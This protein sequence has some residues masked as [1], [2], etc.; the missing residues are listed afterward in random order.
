MTE[1][2]G[3]T[4]LVTGAA[5]GMGRLMALRFAALGGRVVLWDLDEAGVTRAADEIAA[6][7]GANVVADAVDV[8]DRE[9]V[10]E[11]A[12]QATERAGP[13]DVLVHSAGVTHGGLLL[14]HP[15]EVIEQTLR[16]NTL[17]LFW[18]TKAFLPAMLERNDGHVVTMGSAS[19]I[20]GVAR[21]SAYSASKHAAL[22]FN[23]SLRAEL[24]RIAPGVRTTVVNPYY[25]DTGLFEGAR[26]KY[27]WLLPILHAD[28][29]AERVVRAVQRD[30]LVVSLPLMVKVAPWLRVLPA[31]VVDRIA[32]LLGVH[33]S[34]EGFVG[35]ARSSRGSTAA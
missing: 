6:R 31:R 1:V 3:R 7:T 13:A 21:L 33:E 27:P 32:D 14:D 34:M 25:V 8:G 12:R 29:V 17:A 15:D 2:A 28:D 22:G 11:A 24:R 23:E 9:R 19:G 18:V 26:S 35:R 30:E 10:Y 5:S 16:V 20:T 4:V